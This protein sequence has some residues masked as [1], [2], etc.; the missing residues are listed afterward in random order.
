MKLVGVT[1]FLKRVKNL[2]FVF[3]LG[4]SPTI[5]SI[6]ELFLESVMKRVRKQSLR[7]G[8]SSNIIYY[9]TLNVCAEFSILRY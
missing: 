4:T 9:C 6:D 5:D 3:L 1:L 8:L 2:P 7:N